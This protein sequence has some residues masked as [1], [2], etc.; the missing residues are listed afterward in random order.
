MNDTKQNAEDEIKNGADDA[1]IISPKEKSGEENLNVKRKSFFTSTI[2]PI[3]IIIVTALGIA[4]ASVVIWRV[5]RFKNEQNVYLPNSAQQILLTQRLDAE[6]SERREILR[7]LPYSIAPAQLDV[8]ARA[9]IIVDASNGCVIYEKNADEIIP[10]ASMTKLVSMYVVF[11]E[12]ATGRISLDDVVPLPPEC[13][14]A[15]MPPHSSLMFLGRNQRVTLDE[16]L[17]GTAICSGND[18][19][20]ALAFY[21]CGGMEQFIERMNYEVEKLGLAHTHFV[22]SSGYSELN[23]TTARE[24]AA[25]ARVYISR[26][27]E[28]LARYHSKLS[29]TY[30]QEHNL[31]PEDVG[32]P[33]S[34]DWSNGLPENIT[35]GIKQDNTNKL[36]GKL[37]GCDGLKTGFIDESGYN[38]ALTAVRDG[39]RFLSVT[40][41]GPGRN[42]TEGNANRNK[43]GTTLMEW[44]FGTFADSTKTSLLHPYLV[45]VT[46]AREV[47]THLVPAFA[48]E[49]LTVPFITGESPREAADSVTVDISLP[50]YIDGGTVAGDAYGEVNFFLGK[51]LLMKVPLVA[52]RDIAEASFVTRLADGALKKFV[53]DRN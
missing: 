4:Y 45:R 14:A 52:D 41:G 32:K 13:W 17:L 25:F 31:A 51:V 33:R 9:A 18:A 46:G 12:I 1:D 47:Y 7:K 6:Y 28:S 19:A 16:L 37:E 49:T 8:S 3:A 2:L 53:F 34:Q 38:L 29:F 42:V 44:A 22:E 24:M 43:D 35:M 23:T 48:P 36:L 5:Y 27:P 30:P 50:A 20:Y 39:T 26:Y 21:V 15:N 11:Q 10:P 40:M